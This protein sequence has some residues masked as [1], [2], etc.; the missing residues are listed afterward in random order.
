MSKRTGREFR[1]QLGRRQS[2]VEAGGR[3]RRGLRGKE[4]QGHPPLQGEGRGIHVDSSFRAP[5][6]AGGPEM[7]LT[8]PQNCLPTVRERQQQPYF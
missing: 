4:P 1:L 5:K 8:I 7:R 2:W 6:G 3:A